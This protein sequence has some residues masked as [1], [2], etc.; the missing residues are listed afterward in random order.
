[1]PFLH[2]EIHRFCIN[3]FFMI[4][5][6][7]LLKFYDIEVFDD[8]LKL[9]LSSWKN[10]KNFPWKKLIIKIWEKVNH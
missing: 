3:I 7:I 2:F 8:V 10:I 1:M 6:Q 5:T 9:Y 4:F